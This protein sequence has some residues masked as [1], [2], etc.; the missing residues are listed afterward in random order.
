MVFY[1]M[2]KAVTIQELKSAVDEEKR[3]WIQIEI[4]KIT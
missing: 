1:L 2:Q 3:S 4:I